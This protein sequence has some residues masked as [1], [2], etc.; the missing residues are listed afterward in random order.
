VKPGNFSV[1]LLGY[2][3]PVYFRMLLHITGANLDSP[4]T[5]P[6]DS[7][8]SVLV[9]KSAGRR[10][11]HP[12]PDIIVVVARVV[13]VAIRGTAIIRLVE[14]RTATFFM[15]APNSILSYECD[16]AKN[17]FGFM[18]SVATMSLPTKKKTSSERRYSVS[19]GRYPHV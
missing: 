19:I 14:P 18:T 16:R 12:K 4:S 17:I 11:H 3:T 10:T 1:T 2:L 13:V 6:T 9:Q 5:R 8:L 7:H 15:F